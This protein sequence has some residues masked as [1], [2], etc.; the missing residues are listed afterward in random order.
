MNIKINYY[1]MTFISAF[2]NCLI[3]KFNKNTKLKVIK[4]KL[5]IF[6]NNLCLYV[7]VTL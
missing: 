3:S 2:K 7:N 1:P 6:Y 4:F 5:R